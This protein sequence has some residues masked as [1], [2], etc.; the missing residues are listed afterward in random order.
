MDDYYFQAYRDSDEYKPY[1]PK[2]LTDQEIKER[3]RQSKER[4]KKHVIIHNQSADR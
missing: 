3:I 1:K 2:R 4:K